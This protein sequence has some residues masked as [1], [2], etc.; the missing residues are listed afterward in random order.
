[1]KTSLVLDADLIR[2]AALLTG[3]KEKA[4]LVRLGLEALIARESARRLAELNGTEK[5]LCAP[6]RRRARARRSS[7]L[8]VLT[9]S[10]V[11]EDEI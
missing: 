6:R 1:M 8:L 2:K 4:A 7:R 10:A 5:K 11:V 9:S 3:T